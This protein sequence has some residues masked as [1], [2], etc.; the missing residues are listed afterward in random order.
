MQKQINIGDTWL[1]ELE[2]E[3]QQP[4]MQEL[5]QFLAE[6]KA[7]KKPILPHS[8]LWFNAL[9]TT[10]LDQV[11]VVIIGQDPYPTVGHAHGLC[12]SV[13]PE[14][15]P[16]PKSLINIY[17]ELQN[18]LGIDNFH[19]GYLQHWAKQ[20]VLLLNSVLTVQAGSAASHRAKGW[21]TFTDKIIA[22]INQQAEHVVFILWGKYAQDKGAVIDSSRHL[23]LK[24]AHPSPLSA[25]RGFFGSQ[26]FS[27]VN[28]YLNK[29][30]KAPIDW[31]I[32]RT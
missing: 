17:K 9:R 30:G 23:I 15:K 28:H 10:P 26:P 1:A 8:S 14:V 11:K 12:F 16:L 22:T 31:E 25:Y 3:F 29:Q 13:L 5:K 18:D 21:E 19:T 7:Q 24:A 6:E 4:Y 20:G 32:P 2:S 27:H